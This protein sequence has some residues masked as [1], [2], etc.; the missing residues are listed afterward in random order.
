V[1][2]GVSGLRAFRNAPVPS[3]AAGA[4]TTSGSADESAEAGNGVEATTGIAGDATRS[5]SDA[6][7]SVVVDTG[8]GSAP[9]NNDFGD[10]AETSS[11]AE[12]E[13]ASQDTGTGDCAGLF[14]EDFEQGQID[15]SKWDILTGAG[16]TLNVDEQTVAH[17]KYAMHVHG[18]AGRG[19]L[20]PHCHQKCPCGAECKA[21]FGRAYFFI[22]PK[23]TSG[24][25]QMTFAG[26]NGPGPAEGPGPLP[27]LRYMEVANI[28]GGWQIGFDSP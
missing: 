23:P 8:S 1:T 19:R 25:T 15:V 20:C 11:G 16:G 17:G 9:A 7:G 2:L 26:T 21:T 28:G 12:P 10:D 5:E 22:T 24:H 6:P 13:A 14:C 3:G 27:K 4:G 18:L